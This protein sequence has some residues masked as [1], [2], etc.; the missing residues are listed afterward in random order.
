MATGRITKRAVDAIALPAGGKRAYLWDDTL[1]GFGCM[2]TDQGARSYLIQYRVGGRGSPTR[3]VTIGRHG[4][5]WTPDTA[6]DRA[7][8]LLEQVRR[9]V[10]PFEA[11]RQ[12]VAAAKTRAVQQAETEAALQKLACGIAADS[13]VTTAKKSL[14]RWKEQDAIIDRDLRPA[15]GATPLPSI[16]ADDINDQLAKVGERSPSAALKAHVALRAIFA[17]AHAKHRKLFPLSQSP[18]AEVDR[19]QAGGKRERHLDRREQ[20]LMWVA[21]KVLG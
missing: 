14:R 13:Y 1:K 16:G 12:V 7:A 9:K 17:H 3:R 10:D 11:E 6:R 15:F 21:S 2:V 18:F 19:P 8:E 5:P 20:R 4:S